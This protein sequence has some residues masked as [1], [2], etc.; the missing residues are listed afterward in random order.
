MTKRLLVLLVLLFLVG[1]GEDIDAPQGGDTYERP[2]TGVGIGY[3]GKPAIRIGDGSW[4]IDI[5]TG[6]MV[7]VLP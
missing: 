5:G 6:K 2:K 4:G 7:P 3:N 1:C